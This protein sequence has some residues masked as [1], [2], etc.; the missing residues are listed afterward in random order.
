MRKKREGAGYTGTELG[1][2]LGWSASKISRIESGL[3]AVSEVDA[4]IYLTYCGVH[5]D[6]LE[7]LLDLVRDPTDTTSWLQDRGRRLPEDLRTLIYHETTTVAMSAYEPM[8]VHGLL[9]THAYARAVFE[10]TGRVARGDIEM[11]VD[12][13]MDRQGVLR[14][15]N[16]PDCVFYLHEA[17]LRSKVGS[18]RIMHEQILQLVFLTLRPQHQIRVVPAMAGPQAAFGPFALMEFST[19]NPLVYLEFLE[20]SLFLEKPDHIAAYKEIL[21]RLDRAALDLEE[22]RQWLG[23]LA[24]HFDQPEDST[25]DEARATHLA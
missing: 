4:A 19:H 10:A 14:R 16:P 13:R 18:S 20:Q 11:A 24:G 12:A 17:G 5:K 7:D 2:K 9:Q 22:S 6:N 15:L 25:D 3:V 21:N 23:R 8:L 1:E